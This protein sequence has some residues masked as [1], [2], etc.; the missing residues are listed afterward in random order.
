MNKNPYKYL[1]P[2]D[3]EKDDLICIPRES[4]VKKITDS[5]QWGYYWAILGPR[6]IGKTTFLRQIQKKHPNAHYAFFDFTHTYSIEESF[7][8]WIIEE[9]CRQIPPETMP[10]KSE[11]VTENQFHEFL[12][13]FKPKTDKWKRIIF[14]FDEIELIPHIQKFL[15]FWTRVH[16]E[17]RNKNLL[18]QYTAIITGTVDLKKATEGDASPF[19]IAHTLF[20]KDFTNFEAENLIEKPFKK[21]SIDIEKDAIDKIITETGGYPSLLQQIC[22]ILVNTS[23][24]GKKPIKAMD[25]YEAIETLFED[26][27]I[28]ETLSGQFESDV[29]LQELIH[30]ILNGEKIKYSPYE[31]YWIED[32]GVIKEKNSFC[33]IRNGIYERFLKEIIESKPEVRPAVFICYSQ[34]DNKFKESVAQYFTANYRE[35][36]FVWEQNIKR[37]VEELTVEIQKNIEASKVNLFIISHHSLKSQFLLKKEISELLKQQSTEKANIFFLMPTDDAIQNFQQIGKLKWSLHK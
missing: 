16:E 4:D 19:N 6:Q 22:H 21:L 33:A 23:L 28:L 2:L 37:P 15:R 17:S 34:E 3:P 26:C 14:L 10:E 8:S 1:G 35:I 12:V 24:Q 29:I 13:N 36:P 20:L 30:K 7:Y 18:H 9:I 32:A 25:V 5:I 27:F 11:K 31:T